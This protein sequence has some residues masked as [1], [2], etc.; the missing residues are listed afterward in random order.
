MYKLGLFIVNTLVVGLGNPGPK[1]ENNRHNIGFKIVELLIKKLGANNI[2]NK[3]FQGE[4]YRSGTLFFL[5]PSTYM[6]L[7]GVSVLAVKEY[8]SIEKVIVVHDDLELG[9]GAMRFKKSGGHGGHN[10]L[11]SIDEKIGKE[12]CRVR[13][14]IGKPEHKSEVSSHVLSDFSKEEGKSLQD[15]ESNAVEAIEELIQ[16]SLEE[17]QQKFTKKSMNII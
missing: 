16:N 9:F 17:V 13:V 1:Y 8:F 14:G 6:N 11:K 4:L 12:Y 3:K 10:G 7:S 2:S 15:I 5:K